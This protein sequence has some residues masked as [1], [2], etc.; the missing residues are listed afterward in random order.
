MART[1]TGNVPLGIRCNIPH[2]KNDLD[3]AV[4][5]ASENNFE[6]LDLVGHIELAQVQT[7]LD[8]GLAIGSVDLKQPW[9]DLMSPDEGRRR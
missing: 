3:A 7:V 8:A 1:H 2:W 5:F 4:Q 6:V 9:S